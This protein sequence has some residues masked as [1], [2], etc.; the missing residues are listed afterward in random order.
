M[1]TQTRVVMRGADTLFSTQ[2][3]GCR[4][5]EDIELELTLAKNNSSRRYYCSNTA[6]NPTVQW[7]VVVLLAWSSGV[8]RR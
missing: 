6:T 1:L 3:T 7:G 8:D 2:L 5:S 4:R